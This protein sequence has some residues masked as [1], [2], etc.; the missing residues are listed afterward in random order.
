MIL[1]LMQ[2]VTSH[3]PIIIPSH[4]NQDLILCSIVSILHFLHLFLHQ[5]IISLII[6]LTSAVLLMIIIIIHLDLPCILV[7][8]QLHLQQCYLLLQSPL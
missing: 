4:Q 8:L 2:I 3:S 1:H 7:I 5:E 6:Y